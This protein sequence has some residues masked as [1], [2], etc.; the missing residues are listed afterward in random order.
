MPVNPEF[1]FESKMAKKTRNLVIFQPLKSIQNTFLSQEF[2]TNFGKF[3]SFQ[4]C[5]AILRNTL[6]VFRLVMKDRFGIDWVKI[7]GKRL[8]RIKMVS[9]VVNS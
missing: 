1:T 2:S 8:M 5:Q 4:G 6:Y 3:Q 9:E 7:I